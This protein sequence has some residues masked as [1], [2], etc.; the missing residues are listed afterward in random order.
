MMKLREHDN[1][2]VIFLPNLSTI[3]AAKIS[4]GVSATTTTTKRKNS[5]NARKKK[6]KKKND[7]ITCQTGD[8]HIEVHVVFI[9]HLWWK[10]CGRIAA[11]ISIELRSHEYDSIIQKYNAKEEEPKWN[12][13]PY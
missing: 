2:I 8:K 12:S 5:I 10:I 13:Y 4:P 9:L 7:Q 11:A 1:P 3:I 6:G